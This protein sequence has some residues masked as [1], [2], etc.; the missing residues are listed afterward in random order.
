MFKISNNILRQVETIKNSHIG[1][2]RYIIGDG[3]SIKWFDLSFFSD[4]PGIDLNKK[5]IYLGGGLNLLFNIYG[6][7][8]TNH[9][10]KP[11]ADK[12][13]NYEYQIKAF[14]TKQYNDMKCARKYKNEGL[15]ASF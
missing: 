13:L 12:Y 14:E 5:A 15:N 4:K 11:I 10:W 9:I 8:Y 6:K 7:R 1:N 2:S 3:V